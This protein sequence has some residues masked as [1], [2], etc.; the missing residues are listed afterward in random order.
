M[1]FFPCVFGNF[2]V[3]VYCQKKLTV[4]QTPQG[5]ISKPKRNDWQRLQPWFLHN[6]EAGGSR[7]EVLFQKRATSSLDALSLLGMRVTI[8]NGLLVRVYYVY[9]YMNI[10]CMHS[11]YTVRFV[12]YCSCFISYR[13]FRYSNHFRI[14]ALRALRSPVFS[15]AIWRCEWFCSILKELCFFFKKTFGLRSERKKT[16]LGSSLS[17]TSKCKKEPIENIREFADLYGSSTNQPHPPLQGSS[18]KVS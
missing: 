14:Q 9:V 6:I 17:S 1:Y 4:Q 15:F 3:C 13:T 7:F 16:S 11:T 8:V 12:I 18:P 10:N 2:R 5:T